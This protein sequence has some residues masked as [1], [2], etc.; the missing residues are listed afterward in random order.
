MS[1]SE[2]VI[3]L[4]LEDLRPALF[5]QVLGGLSNTLGE[6]E[7]LGDVN[8]L[9]PEFK[10]VSFYIAFSG[11]TNLP[12]GIEA[13]ILIAFR[14]THSYYAK[15]IFLGDEA[16]YMRNKTGDGVNAWSEWRQV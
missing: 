9:I 6:E 15:Q 4:I 5:Q 3:L 10:R 13:G 14:W 16:I 12:A 8:T 11:C 2:L 1:D 7:F